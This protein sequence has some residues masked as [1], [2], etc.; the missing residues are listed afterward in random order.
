[1]FHVVPVNDLREHE[2]SEDCWCIP[3]ADEEEPSVLVHNSM[4]QRESY[5]DNKRKYH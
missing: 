1:M 5:E 4:D 2:L 3:I